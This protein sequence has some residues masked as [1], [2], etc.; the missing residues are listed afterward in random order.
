VAHNNCK[1]TAGW[2]DCWKEGVDHW[3]AGGDVPALVGLI[4]KISDWLFGSPSDEDREI[5]EEYYKEACSV[6]YGCDYPADMA[7]H[8]E[9]DLIGTMAGDIEG[10]EAGGTPAG[11][12]AGSLE[13]P[14]ITTPDTD[15]S[16]YEYWKIGYLTSTVD[17]NGLVKDNNFTLN[18][19]TYIILVGDGDIYDA[20]TFKGNVGT[21]GETSLES[22]LSSIDPYLVGSML[23]DEELDG[24][25]SFQ[26]RQ[27]LLDHTE[28][29]YFIVNW[30]YGD[31]YRPG[32]GQY[33]MAGTQYA[34]TY[35]GDKGPIKDAYRLTKGIAGF[36]A[37]LEEFVADIVNSVIGTVPT[38]TEPVLN[39]KKVK[40]KK[41]S[42][43]DLSTFEQLESGVAVGTVAATTSTAAS[44]TTTTGY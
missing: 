16:L 7:D 3:E 37:S 43:E 2:Q 38:I 29:E 22:A 6:T 1:D 28:I 5:V 9:G 40:K 27:Q 20:A 18:Y 30:A 35:H 39:F 4:Q 32:F 36:E 42:F 15:I 41:I 12:M 34:I 14:L 33:D 11:D 21:R 8:D 24:I 10:T 19:G 26:I 23:T 31:T 25:S 13:E 17:S 44:T